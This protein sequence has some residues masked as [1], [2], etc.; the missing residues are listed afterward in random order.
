[1]TAGNRATN[2]QSFIEAAIVLMFELMRF[3]IGG[4]Y[5]IGGDAHFATLQCTH[6]EPLRPRWQQLKRYPAT[7]PHITGF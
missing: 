4:I 2:V 1:M 7:M 6:G 3:D 5:L